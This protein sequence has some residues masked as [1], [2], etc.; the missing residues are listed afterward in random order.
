[1]LTLNS[2][3][4]NPVSFTDNFSPAFSMNPDAAIVLLSFLLN[5]L[6]APFAV[7]AFPIETSTPPTLANTSKL[8]PFIPFNC[9]NAFFAGD[10]EEDGKLDELTEEED[11][12]ELELLEL[13]DEE[14]EELELRELEELELE[15]DDNDEELR[16]ERLDLELLELDGLDELLEELDGDDDELRLEELGAELD[17]LEPLDFPEPFNTFDIESFDID[18]ESLDG[19]VLTDIVV[20]LLSPIL[21]S[22]LVVPK[23]TPLTEPAEDIPNDAPDDINVVVTGAAVTYVG[24]GPPIVPD[25]K[26]IFGLVLVAHSPYLFTTSEFEPSIFKPLSNILYKSATAFSCPA[27]GPRTQ[28]PL[29]PPVTCNT[30]APLCVIDSPSFCTATSPPPSNVALFGYCGL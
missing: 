2:P 5:F 7:F 6:A 25:A 9:F 18:D 8:P 21:L 14:L 1:L 20:T 23:L 3:F 17:E 19:A 16:L 12:D 13:D 24:A 29:S 26:S 22:V 15:L 10:D 4:V 27:L 11:G 30:V 28:L